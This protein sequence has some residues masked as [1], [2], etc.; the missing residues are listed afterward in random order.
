MR[1]MG[2]TMFDLKRKLLAVAIGGLLSMG[3]FAQRKG[4][5]KRPPKDNPRVVVQPKEKQQQPPPRND[6][7]GDRQRGDKKGKP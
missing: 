2:N 3:A 7:Q 4:D 1:R 5:D 6:N